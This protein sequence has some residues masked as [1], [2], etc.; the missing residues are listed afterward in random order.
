LIDHG[1]VW[2]RLFE[3][4]DAETLT[5]IG[6]AL[7]TQAHLHDLEADLTYRRSERDEAIADFSLAQRIWTCLGQADRVERC[8]HLIESLG[9]DVRGTA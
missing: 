1:F 4:L 2:L 5:R 6:K 8:R 9:H 3:Q 7:E